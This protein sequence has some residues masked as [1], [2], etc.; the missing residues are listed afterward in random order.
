MEKN[1]KTRTLGLNGP[2]VSAIGLGRMG[3]SFGLG[4]LPRRQEALTLAPDD[5]AALDRLASEIPIQGERY[6]ESFRRL[7]DR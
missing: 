2:S 6:S 5:L 1:M 7:V 4:R 3:I